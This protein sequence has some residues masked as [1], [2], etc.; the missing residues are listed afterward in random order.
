MKYLRLQ[1]LLREEMSTSNTFAAR[2]EFARKFNQP[3]VSHR[4]INGEKVL[5][6]HS[7]LTELTCV[8]YACLLA[9]KTLK[10][11]QFI[12]KTSID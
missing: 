8:E 5:T 1:S 6:D 3:L 7:I 11:Y 10:T 2:I 12:S 4:C 9:F